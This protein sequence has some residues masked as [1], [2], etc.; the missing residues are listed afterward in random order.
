[1]CEI[2]RETGLTSSALEMEL[3]KVQAMVPSSS[4][5]NSFD[6]SEK[7]EAKYLQPNE[8]N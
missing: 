1:M 2:V 8:M 4:M 5:V 6:R 3:M 7:M